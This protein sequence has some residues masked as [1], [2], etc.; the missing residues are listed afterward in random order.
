MLHLPHWL[1]ASVL[2]VHPPEERLQ[3]VL[4]PHAKDREEYFGKRLRGSLFPKN[5]A[6]RLQL[7]RTDAKLPTGGAGS[8][9]AHLAKPTLELSRLRETRY[10]LLRVPQRLSSQPAVNPDLQDWDW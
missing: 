10:R 6:I 5:R 2:A 8:L 4:S 1:F 7:L 3:S 9:G